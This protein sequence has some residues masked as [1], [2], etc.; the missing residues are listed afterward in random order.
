[1]PADRSRR[2][3]VW[4]GLALLVLYAIWL[5][6]PYLRSIA[7]RN[8]AVSTWLYQA[9]SPIDGVVVSILN[10]NDRIG[11]DGRIATVGNPR[12][13]SAP[14]SRARAALDE[15][16]TRETSSARIVGEF[17][18][19]VA[20]RTALAEDFA[21]TFKANLDARITGLTAY[22]ALSEQ[23]LKVERAEAARLSSMFAIGSESQSAAE[24]ATSR[25]ADLERAIVDS[26]TSLNRSRL[27]REAAN[28]GVFMLDD[29]SDG[30]IA[31]RQLEDARQHLDRARADLAAARESVRGAQEVVDE[32]TR[33]FGHGESSPATGRPGGTLWANVVAPGRAVSLGAPV[34]QWVDCRVLFVD[35][36][37]SDAEL[38]LLR[39]GL[40]ATVVFEGERRARQGSVLLMRGAASTIGPADLAAVAKGRHAGTGQVLVTLETTPDDIAACP[41]GRAAFV[42]FPDVTVL[43]IIRARLRW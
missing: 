23:R 5:G 42:H 17:E 20:A 25:V 36:P 32:A 27:H 38:A 43:D 29:G 9:T 1:M 15:A 21:G 12:A 16:R 6:G 18:R 37:V 13:D 22:V 10:I 30:A 14:V 19:L 8:A 26:Q 28:T 3:V 41:V 7:V 4:L 24:A 31:Q 39:P 34:A 11:D 40:P 33:L 2:L 35:T